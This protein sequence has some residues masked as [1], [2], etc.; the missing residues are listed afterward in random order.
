MSNNFKIIQNDSP[1]MKGDAIDSIDSCSID[2]QYFASVAYYSS[3]SRFKYA[4]FDSY[5]FVEKSGICN[6]C[7]IMTAN[8]PLILSIPLLDGRSQRKP[9]RDIQICWKGRWAADHWRSIESAYGRSPWYDHYSP[10]LRALYARKDTYL[11]DFLME[12]TEWILRSL[13]VNMERNYNS[14][15]PSVTSLTDLRLASPPTTPQGHPSFLRAAQVY[16]QVFMER[17][18]FVGN[19]SILDLLFCLGPGANSY[20]LKMSV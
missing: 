10:Q 16:P 2:L 6:R 17:H 18:G 14:L 7:R 9:V 3:L 4:Y 15:D 19:L 1:P 5:L 8:G 13:K 20:L 12:T 11:I